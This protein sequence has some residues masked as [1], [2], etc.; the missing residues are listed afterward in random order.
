MDIVRDLETGESKSQRTRFRLREKGLS[1]SNGQRTL[2]A[3]S[4]ASPIVSGGSVP[5]VG[6]ERL[7]CAANWLVLATR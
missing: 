6:H 2:L 1:P 5:G 3:C 7:L 4:W